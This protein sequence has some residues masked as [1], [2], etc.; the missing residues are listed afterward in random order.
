MTTA[1]VYPVK[2]PTSRTVPTSRRERKTRKR[3]N[4]REICQ[5]PRGMRLQY[6]SSTL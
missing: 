5:S 4:C 2:V 6:T 1:N 3:A